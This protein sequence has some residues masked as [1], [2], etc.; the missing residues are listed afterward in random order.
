MF[1][2]ARPVGMQNFMEPCQLAVRDYLGS[3]FDP[4]SKFTS[5]V[6]WAGDAQGSKTDDRNLLC[7]LQLPGPDGRPIPFKG[8]RSPSWINPRSGLPGRVWASTPSTDRSTEMPVTARRR[9]PWR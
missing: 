7:G 5:S 6:L 3:H 9:T 4:N 2:V 1:E 8:Q